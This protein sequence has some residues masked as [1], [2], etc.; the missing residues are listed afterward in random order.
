M[1]DH[2]LHYLEFEKRYSG[3]TLIAY[4][5]DLSDFFDFL[6]ENFGYVS[7]EKVDYKIIRR[8]ITQLMDHKISPRTIKRKISSLKAFYRYL[9]RN[10]VVVVNPVVNVITPKTEK[11]LTAFIPRSYME[12]IFDKRHF[13]ADFSGLRDQVIMEMLYATGIRRS[14]L[15]QLKDSDVDLSNNTVKVLGKGN[16]TRI[17][18]ISVKLHDII[19]DYFLEREKEFSM[20]KSN[21]FLVTNE[22]K[23]VY[24]QLIYRKVKYY[25][26]MSVNLEKRSPHVM[27]HTFATHLMDEGADINAVKE[28]L[29][30]SGLA[31]TQIYTH[32][33]IDKLKTTY[34]HAH[35]RA[36]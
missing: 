36:K 35:P 33:T 4:K 28:L 8:W 12:D 3:H 31:A 11:R 32:N 17:I 5:K 16:K 9:Q 14:E 21:S 30:H 23:S 10:E 15:V 29:G 22:G 27:R 19:K 7:V 24:P 26:S 20:N 34:K 2:F 1:V 6:V 25:L 13:I 18:P